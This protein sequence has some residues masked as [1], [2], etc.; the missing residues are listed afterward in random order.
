MTHTTHNLTPH[1]LVTR[2]RKI[3]G[4]IRGLQRMVVRGDSCTQVLT[5]IAAARAALAVV[6][7]GLVDCE[8]HRALHDGEARGFEAAAADILDAVEL[9]VDR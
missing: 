4:Q 1:E 5:Q 7:F 6:G 9:L 8:V 3:E 2:L